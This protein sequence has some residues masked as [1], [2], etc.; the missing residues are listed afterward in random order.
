MNYKDLETSQ[1]VGLRSQL[2]QASRAICRVFALNAENRFNGIGSG[3]AVF[4]GEYVLTAA[5]VVGAG[6]SCLVASLG[7]PRWGGDARVVASES[8]DDIALLQLETT[9]ASVLALSPS[10]R[11]AGQGPLVCWRGSADDLDSVSGVDPLLSLE[12]VGCL[13]LGTLSVRCIDGRGR[14]GLAGAFR[15]G[16]SGGPVFDPLSGHVVGVASAMP[17]Y[18]PYSVVG[19]WADHVREHEDLS[20]ELGLDVETFLEAQLSCGIGIA[21]PSNTALDWLSS[22]GVP[23]EGKP[24]VRALE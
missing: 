8:A 22:L 16:M 10:Q 21:V 7:P 20:P 1:P 18:D 4:G 15:H 24:T 6:A 3:F 9:A 12:A 2:E 11:S 23:T 5:H 19:A 13:S 17:P 14:L